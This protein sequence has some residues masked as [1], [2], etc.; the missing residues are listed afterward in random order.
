MGFTVRKTKNSDGYQND[1]LVNSIIEK[2]L[3]YQASIKLLML[4]EFNQ[5]TF[6]T[7]SALNLLRPG[8]ERYNVLDFGGG[9]GHHLAEAQRLF[10]DII[11]EWHIVESEK[12]T[13]VAEEKINHV[14]LAFHSKIDEVKDV[15][16]DL[17]YCNSALQ[18]TKEPLRTLQKLLQLQH[19]NL[20]LTRIPL[21]L[22]E[23][24]SY[25]Q[26]SRLTD[27]GPGPSKHSRSKVSYKCQVASYRDVVDIIKN[28][29]EIIGIFKDT[30]WDN[31]PSKKKVFSFTI[32][33]KLPSH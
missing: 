23:S 13:E 15:Q 17:I 28:Q 3:N 20:F 4:P 21:T 12:M 26:I 7:F 5:Q 14:N 9:G 8:K 31:L 2:N 16:F 24:F 33:A 11:F 32:V 1:S 29:A 19:G 27:N 25:S 22:G 30:A 18:Y 10:P 6:S